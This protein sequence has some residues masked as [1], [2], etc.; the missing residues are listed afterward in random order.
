M[1]KKLPV[2]ISDFRKVIEGNYYYIDKSLF[3]KELIEIS[4]EIVLITRPRRFG[5]TLNLN[6]LECFFS[7]LNKDSSD[8][9]ENLGIH[10]HK[11]IMK[12]QGQYPV[13]YIS[14]KDEKFDNWNEAKGSIIDIII[15]QFIKYKFILDSDCLDEIEK[16]IYIKII[17]GEAQE[18]HYNK[19]LGILSRFLYKYYKQKVMIFI[20]EYDVPINTGYI[21]NYYKEVVAF[22][23]IFLSDAL[24]DNQYIEKGVLTGVLRIAKESIFSGLNNLKVYTVM[25]NHFSSR[26]GF[27]E[28]EVEEM[29]KYYNVESEI[30]NIQ[31]WYNG[32]KYGNSLIYNPWSIIELMENYNEFGV[33]N[34]SSYWVNTADDILIRNILAKS[35]VDVKQEMEALINGDVILKQIKQDLIM[36]RIDESSESIWSFLL[37]TGYLNVVGEEY[38]KDRK[39]YYLKIPNKEIMLLFE[40]IVK[41]YIIVSY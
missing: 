20:D 11:E 26:F 28:K 13:I 15:S 4:A 38:I 14:F 7:V 22:F 40:D 6:M 18:R 35:S 30:Q 17:N 29:L 31:S 3:I 10:N 34:L 23:R 9:F 24:K 36:N 32:Y 12:Y 21:N 19:A 16:S 8:L 33:I 1:N 2:G 25:D 39:H 27:T 5:K 37:Y 41:I